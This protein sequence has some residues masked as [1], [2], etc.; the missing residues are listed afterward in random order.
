MT[1]EL[2]IGFLRQWLNENRITDPEK[3]VTTRELEHWLRP[4]LEEVENLRSLHTEDEETFAGHV[5]RMNEMQSELE[6]LKK[7][8]L[9]LH[10]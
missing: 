9:K 2:S 8:N 1:P 10:A 5:K 3:M 6:R 7:A 4:L